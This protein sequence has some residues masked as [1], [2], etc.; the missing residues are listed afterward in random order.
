MRIDFIVNRRFIFDLW[1]EYGDSKEGGIGLV[2]IER[3]GD[4]R[5]ALNL[6]T[7]WRKRS[8]DCDLERLSFL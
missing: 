5:D 6:S 4:F 1:P 3:M 8:N 2:Y 7:C